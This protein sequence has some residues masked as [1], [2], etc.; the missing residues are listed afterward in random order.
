[1]KK[2]EKAEISKNIEILNT[3]FIN[4]ASDIEALFYSKLAILELC[5][6]LE[7]SMERI[8]WSCAI[9]NVK[10][11]KNRVFIEEKIIKRNHG[12]SYKYNFRKMLIPIVGCRGIETIEDAADLNTI[13]YLDSITSSL[14]EYR[15]RHAHTYLNATMTVVA[16]SAIMK[17]LN[18][19]FQAL[20]EFQ[21][22]MKQKGL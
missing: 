3:L 5:G 19:V 6:W 10:D 21:D 20:E 2:M 9:R 14:K 11:K 18:D 1:M 13:S 16:P 17:Y 8:A 7:N 22:V 12:F 15:N 4:N